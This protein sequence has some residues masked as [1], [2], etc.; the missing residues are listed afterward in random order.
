[1]NKIDNASTSEIKKAAFDSKN[2]SKSLNN[3]TIKGSNHSE[4]PMEHQLTL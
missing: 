4:K 2:A 3:L 1:M